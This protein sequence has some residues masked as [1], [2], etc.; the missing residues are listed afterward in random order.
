MTPVA[1]GGGARDAVVADLVAEGEELDGLVAPLELTGWATPTPAPGWTVAHQIAHLASTD[2]AALASVALGRGPR[3]VGRYLVDTDQVGPALRA[4]GTSAGWAARR[5][6][7]RWSP[8]DLSALVDALA[9]AGSRVDPPR[10]L[11]RWRTGRRRLAAGLAD[12]RTSAKLWWIG[13]RLGP[14]S[15]ATA[16]LMETWAHGQDVADALG[17]ERE[18]TSRLRH[19]ARL[20]VRTR[21]F[22]YRMHGL[23]PPATEFRVELAAPDGS[24]WAWGPEGAANRVTGPAL[25][26]CLLVTRRRHPDDLRLVAKGAA[27]Q[28]LPIAQA[29][30]GSPG[31]GREA[32]GEPLGAQ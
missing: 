19:I 25:D 20:G 28:W 27:A 7:R 24:T 6:V 16:R 11:T 8:E 15:M 4:A 22:G 23:E 17:V 12:V 26:F 5:G 18:P 30:A 13:M 29:Y 1:D 14:A 32:A 31:P 21:D 10:L 9:Q 2:T 3:A